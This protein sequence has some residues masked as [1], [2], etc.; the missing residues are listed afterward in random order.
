M[1]LLKKILGEV[2]LS[3][4]YAWLPIGVF[5]FVFIL[6]IFLFCLL[7]IRFFIFIFFNFF[8]LKIDG[9]MKKSKPI[10]YSMYHLEIK[11]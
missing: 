11:F 10:A 8:F 6:F 3:L 9:L 5:C 1:L 4:F 2:S 7:F